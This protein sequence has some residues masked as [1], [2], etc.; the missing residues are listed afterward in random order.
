MKFTH[1]VV[2]AGNGKPS[3]DQIDSAAM[4]KNAGQT[5]A[6][7]HT[8]KDDEKQAILIDAKQAKDI[9]EHQ[10]SHGFEIHELDKPENGEPA[11][12]GES[13]N[14]SVVTLLNTMT[15]SEHYQVRLLADLLMDEL[16]LKSKI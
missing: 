15:E 5:F 1:I 9:E 2:K 8:F 14:E 13:L 6:I 10:K 11:K 7:I 12:P 16:H 3:K 4:V